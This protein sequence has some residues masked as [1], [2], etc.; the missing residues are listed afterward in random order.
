M[1]SSHVSRDQGP[2]LAP[3]HVYSHSIC[4]RKSPAQTQNQ[5]VEKGALCPVGETAK[6]H[7]KECGYKEGVTLELSGVKMFELIWKLFPLAL[8][9]GPSPL[10]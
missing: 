5:G 8:V 7:G 2:K 6:V 10:K 4:Q 1:E 3:C 9:Q